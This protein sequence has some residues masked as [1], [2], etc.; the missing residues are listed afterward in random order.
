M[1]SVVLS[2]YYTYL[3]LL[4]QENM[5]PGL[6]IDFFFDILIREVL[7][8]LSLKKKVAYRMLI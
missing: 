7:R 8:P 1:K 5:I 6:N 3:S 2:A 4:S